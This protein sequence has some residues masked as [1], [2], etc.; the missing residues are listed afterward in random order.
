MGWS[1]TKHIIYI[2]S[3]K[4]DCPGRC[5]QVSTLASL[6][7]MQWSFCVTGRKTIG[8]MAGH[9]SLKCNVE[10]V[11]QR[12]CEAGKA[13]IVLLP[14]Y[15]RVFARQG[16]RHLMPGGSILQYGCDWLVTCAFPIAVMSVPPRH[17]AGKAQVASQ[18]GFC[19][20]RRLAPI[21]NITCSR[22]PW[23]V[24]YITPLL[25][26]IPFPF[27]GFCACSIQRLTGR[28]LPLN[29]PFS[30]PGFSIHGP[31]IGMSRSST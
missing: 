3:I 29:P 4:R 20:A 8:G 24:T 13:Q 22:T 11:M 15:I 21:D 1:K 2:Y 18:L 5:I 31:P 23:L 17:E 19:A 28:L 25:E 12:G 30:N 27:R 16:S 14:Y 10:V 6:F 9:V 26:F 7:L